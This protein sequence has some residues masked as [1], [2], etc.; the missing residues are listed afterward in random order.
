MDNQQNRG[1]KNVVGQAK[2][3]G[4]RGS[5]LGTGPVG[6]KTGYGGRPGVSSAPGNHVKP[7]IPGQAPRPGGNP[8]YQGRP[9]ERPM[10]R[11]TGF[12]PVPTSGGKKGGLGKLLPIIIIAIIAIFVIKSLG[13]GGSVDSGI[14]SGYPSSSQSSSGF[15]NI[16]SSSG[17]ISSKPSYYSSNP[18]SAFFGGSSSGSSYYSAQTVSSG[19]DAGNN[20][21]TLDT[22]VAPGARDKRTKL[23]GSGRDTVTL[24]VYMC[25]TDLESQNAMAS[26]DL[27]EMLK[28]E[29]SDK[30]NII[31]YTGGCK[32]WKNSVVSSSVNQIY[33]VEA[34]GLKCL[35]DNEGKASMVNPDTLSGFIK[36]CKKNYEAS[37]YGLIFWDHGGGSISGYGYDEKYSSAGSMTL[38]Q[39]RTALKA[40]GVSF[41]FIGFDACLMATLE[42]AL[43]VEPYADYMIASEESEP[44]I[45]W[46]Y[47]NWLTKLSSNTS[48]ATIDVGKIIVDDFVSTCA[49]QCAGQK[50]T[51][52]LIDLAELKA[53]VPEEFAEFSLEAIELIDNSSF[54][55]LSSARS[56]S[57]EFASSS[58]IDQVDLVHFVNSVNI[59]GSDELCRAILGAIKYNRTSSN[60]TNAYG[61]SI[62]FPYKRSTLVKS[63]L[64]LYDTLEMDENY[65]ALVKKYASYQSSGQSSYTAASSSGSGASSYGSGY[66]SSYGSGAFQSISGSGYSSSA[67]GSQTISADDIS[68]LLGALFGMKSTPGSDRALGD[69]DPEAIAA[70]IAENSFNPST[71]GFTEKNG[72]KV[73]AL[74]EKQKSLISKV[75]LNVFYDDGEGY[76]DLGLDSNFL[77]DADGDL[78][79]DFDGTWFSIDLQPVAYYYLDTVYG[80][81]GS[82]VITG[83]VPVLINGER[84]ELLISFDKEHSGGYITGAR[85]IYINGE[86]E[87]IAKSMEIEEGAKI[88]FIC[89]YYSY[90]GEYMDSYMLGDVWE[91]SSD[92][93]LGYAEIGYEGISAC[94]RITDI[95]NASYWSPVIE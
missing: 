84:A 81:D 24:M 61:L 17:D 86:T 44:G 32:Q 21:G 7:N 41:D 93:V 50:T 40:G 9:P 82:P 13:G 52:S 70:Y 1:S 76:I 72:G 73:L 29:L 28:A 89:D 35:S 38:P 95:Y 56:G 59:E 11:Q 18:F 69:A 63:A 42:T 15:A 74:T 4:K 6:N 68:S 16:G 25:G 91:Y 64:G 55:R 78:A 36:Y 22:T 46:Y 83:F 20:T 14:G 37:R 23:L 30:V 77:F 87:T 45:G 94:Y 47:T 67:Y 27:Q 88:D 5:G 62:Y 79:G 75:E 71:L 10:A 60:M 54:S 90:S 34:G 19:W 43:M 80:E 49:S 51:L 31:V 12:N 39:I 57:R 66:G 8:S 53:T 58:K 2:G 48:M 3:I 65:T 26:Y 92:A 33:K 85:R